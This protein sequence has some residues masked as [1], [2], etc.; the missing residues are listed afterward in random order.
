MEDGSSGRGGRGRGSRQ[1]GRSQA[2]RSTTRVVRGMTSLSPRSQG[3]QGASS[4][5]ISKLARR[6]QSLIDTAEGIGADRSSARRQVRMAENSAAAKAEGQGA[7]GEESKTRESQADI[8]ALEREV[9]SAVTRELEMRRE[10]RMEGGDE[11]D[12]WW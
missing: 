5:Q 8:D 9:L 12:W 2:P 7:V 3:A 11:R 1:S 6:L 10:R 4:N